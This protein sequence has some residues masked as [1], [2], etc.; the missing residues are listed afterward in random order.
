MDFKDVASK[1]TKIDEWHISVRAAA[2]L[3]GFAFMLGSIYVTFQFTLG[4]LKKNVETGNAVIAKTNDRVEE[5][6]VNQEGF[7]EDQRIFDVTQRSLT[8]EIA[9]TLEYDLY[10]VEEGDTL[11]VISQKLDVPYRTIVDMNED[12]IYNPDDLEEGVLL[13]IPK[14]NRNLDLPSP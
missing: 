9:R 10:R 7:K 12:K 5:V 4:D 14:T 13:K 8:K 1:V 6:L 3:L 11:W 2:K